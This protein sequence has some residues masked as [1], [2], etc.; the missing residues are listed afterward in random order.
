MQTAAADEDPGEVVTREELQ[1]RL[2]PSGYLVDSGRRNPIGISDIRS[3]A[4]GISS[5]HSEAGDYSDVSVRTPAGEIPGSKFSRLTAEEM[6]T[7]KLRLSILG[8]AWISR[9]LSSTS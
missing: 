4:V 1:R 9:R 6:K 5:P 3:A 8:N 7:S 2:W